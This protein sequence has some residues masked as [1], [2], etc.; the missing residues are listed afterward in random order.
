[1]DNWITRIVA[2]LCAL[3]SL[4]LFW[5]LG[6]FFVIPWDAGRMAALSRGELQMIIVPLLAGSAGAWGALHLLAIADRADHPKIYATLRALLI[7]VVIAATI[8][9]AIWS[10]TMTPLH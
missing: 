6:V 2:L 5:V 8:S 7:A 9:G 3:G 10:R 1:M 4:G